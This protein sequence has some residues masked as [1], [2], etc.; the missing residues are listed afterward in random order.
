VLHAQVDRLSGSWKIGKYD[1]TAVGSA[2]FRSSLLNRTT[3]GAS[4]WA[5][6]TLGP[7]DLRLNY[8]VSAVAWRPEYKLRAGKIDENVQ[9][10]YLANLTQHSG[11]D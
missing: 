7:L 5:S 4:L 9:L 3:R 11:E 8:L 2:V 10:D 1:G 6:Q